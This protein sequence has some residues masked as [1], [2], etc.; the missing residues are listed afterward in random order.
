MQ[1]LLIIQIEVQN[2]ETHIVINDALMQEAQ[3]LSKSITKE[4]VVE[5]ALSLLY[6]LKSKLKTGHRGKLN[7]EGDLNEI[8]LDA[9]SR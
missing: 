5:E 4:A 6:G 1:S 3:L 8:R 2:Y 9:L 7:W